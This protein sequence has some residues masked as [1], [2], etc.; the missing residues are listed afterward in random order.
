MEW[1]DTWQISMMMVSMETHIQYRLM[2]ESQG[3]PQSFL[4]QWA[5]SSHYDITDRANMTSQS[6]RT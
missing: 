4:V 1:M 6:N 2:V 3:L 5:A